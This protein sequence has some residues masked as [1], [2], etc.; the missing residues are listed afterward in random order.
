M[1][2]LLFSDAIKSIKQSI[3]LCDDMCDEKCDKCKTAPLDGIPNQFPRK[4]FLYRTPTE[5][6]R[7]DRDYFNLKYCDK[8]MLYRYDGDG[9]Q[10]TGTNIDKLEKQI[11]QTK[12]DKTLYEKIVEQKLFI[13]FLILL[14]LAFFWLFF[15]II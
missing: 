2:S 10:Y 4:G 6:E 7:K 1:F 3:S 11:E 5:F 9:D 13:I 12:H 15:T 8:E 14:L